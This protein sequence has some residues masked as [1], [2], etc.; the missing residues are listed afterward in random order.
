MNKRIEELAEQ[1]FF[2]KDKH[3]L[4]WDE[5]ANADGVDLEKFAELIIWE[6][7]DQMEECFAG[8]K[9]SKEKE[10]LWIESAKTFAAWNG[11]I[12]LS[13][14]KIKDHFGVQE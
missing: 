12:K 10:E 3:G 2:T 4:Y 5:N 1:C 7:V 14:N 13:R 8:S 11:A 6:V 9:T